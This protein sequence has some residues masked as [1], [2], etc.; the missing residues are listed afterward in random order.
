MSS[1]QSSSVGSPDEYVSVNHFV[2][3]RI[4]IIIIIILFCFLCSASNIEMITTPVV[5][6]R[7]AGE[8][9]QGIL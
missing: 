7:S 6:P 3:S 8:L 4:I 5:S 1:T 9:L 2:E